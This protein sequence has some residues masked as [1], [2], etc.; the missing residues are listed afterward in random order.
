MT[1]KPWPVTGETP[2]HIVRSVRLPRPHLVWTRSCTWCRYICQSVDGPILHAWHLCRRGNELVLVVWWP[3][4]E[5]A[6]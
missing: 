2:P 5:E 6:A 1:A 3:K 4:E